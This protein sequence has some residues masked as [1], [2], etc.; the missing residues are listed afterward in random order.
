TTK[1]GA[2]KS[3][4][5]ALPANHILFQD[6]IVDQKYNVY[7][8]H[9]TY[10]IE[11]AIFVKGDGC[12]KLSWHNREQKLNAI[13]VPDDMINIHSLGKQLI[14]V[15]KAAYEV[16]LGQRLLELHPPFGLNFFRNGRQ[17]S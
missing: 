12:C 8:E 5:L 16:Y 15:V 7:I 4:E 13:M 1:K 6:I 9:D 2:I 10:P 17:Q 14:D 3:W 11:T